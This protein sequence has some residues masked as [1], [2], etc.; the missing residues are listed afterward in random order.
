MWTPHERAVLLE[1]LRLYGRHWVQLERAWAER[2]LTTRTAQGLRLE[3]EKLMR[4]AAPLA[5]PRFSTQMEPQLTYTELMGKGMGVPNEGEGAT[6]GAAEEAEGGQGTSW[7]APRPA[8]L[9]LPRTVATGSSG[10]ARWCGPT[11]PRVLYA[12]ASLVR[13][14][15]AELPP[16]HARLM[17]G[18][19]AAAD[20]TLTQAVYIDLDAAEHALWRLKVAARR[21]RRSVRDAEVRAVLTSAPRT[22]P[23]PCIRASGFRATYVLGGALGVGRYLDAH[24]AAAMLGLLSTAAWP[25]AERLLS[26]RALFHAVGNSTARVFVD[27][28]AT[29]AVR[30][31][32]LPKRALRYA[33]LCGGAFDTILEAMR[34]VAGEVEAVLAVESDPDLLAV[35]QAAYFYATSCPRV[36]AVGKALQGSLD[37]VAWTPPC[38]RF[39]KANQLHRASSRRY[40]QRAALRDMQ[41]HARALAQTLAIAHPIIVI[42]EQVD[43]LV[44]HHKAAYR[45]LWRSVAREPYAWFCCVKDAVDLG[46][47]S[48]RRRLGILGVRLD[49]IVV[50]IPARARGAT[51]VCRRC[52]RQMTTEACATCSGS[53]SGGHAAG[54]RQH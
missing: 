43:G 21:R 39:S 12:H 24:D 50:P 9:D 26:P 1:L 20:A 31:A 54:G 45:A 33:T 34:R 2:E 44:T 8:V 30:H 15:A 51:L 38:Q 29:A 35:L 49:A 6:R 42:G 46:A 18:V 22:L 40:L 53:R 32:Q 14:P 7:R 28:L 23:L 17:A 52:R 16:R 3:A 25:I 47:V 36:E 37:V 11:L 41:T 5:E 27:A 4:G 10:R 13:P 48:R 19:R